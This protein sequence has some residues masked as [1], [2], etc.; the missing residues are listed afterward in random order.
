MSV[1]Q[2]LQKLEEVFERTDIEQAKELKAKLEEFRIASLKENL[3]SHPAVKTILEH[4]LARIEWCKNTLINDRGEN[5]E[6]IMDKIYR[7]KIYQELDDL[8]LFVGLFGSDD[9]L[10]E[11][12]R[13]LNREIQANKEFIE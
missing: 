3:R 4:L 10:E 5:R 6:P 12:K 7:I 13:T 8:K 9:E 1:E 11:L 2:D